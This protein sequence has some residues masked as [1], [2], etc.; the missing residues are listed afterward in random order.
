MQSASEDSRTIAKSES[1]H[2]IP[3][4]AMLR[5]TC[6]C[7]AR[8]TNH[9]SPVHMF[10][11]LPAAILTNT[12]APQLVL[13]IAPLTPFFSIP[14]LST[15]SHIPIRS[16]HSPPP[17]PSPSCGPPDVTFTAEDQYQNECAFPENSCITCSFRYPE[18]SEDGEGD[19]KGQ[20]CTQGNAKQ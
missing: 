4:H 14:L 10:F 2:A 20:L 12:P 13:V 18:D 19:R 3:C 16:S 11:S 6:F 15:Y 8:T 17:F 1:C 5:S 9:C 7:I